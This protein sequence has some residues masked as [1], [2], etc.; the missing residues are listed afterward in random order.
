MPSLVSANNNFI[1]IAYTGNNDLN[2]TDSLRNLGLA[3]NAPGGL[4]IRKITFLPSAAGDTIVI[5]D[6]ANGPRV[7]SAIDVLGT[8]DM[9]KDVYESSHGAYK[10]VLVTGKTMY[11]YIHAAECTIS[12]TA[13]IVFELV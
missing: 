11:P 4:R 1:E 6:R 13:I 2:L 9:I 7:F 10:E 8:Y 3:R 12:G 5:R